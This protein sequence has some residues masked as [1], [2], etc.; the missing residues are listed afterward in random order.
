MYSKVQEENTEGTLL[1]LWKY[2]RE[3]L[4]KGRSSGTETLTHVRCNPL[5]R[6]Q[7]DEQKT[8]EQAIYKLYFHLV[9]NGHW[10][11][12]EAL[13]KYLDENALLFI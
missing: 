7:P 13:E 5:Q 8:Q 12:R 3:R 1:S 10:P 6:K 11:E 2:P 9:K 4:D